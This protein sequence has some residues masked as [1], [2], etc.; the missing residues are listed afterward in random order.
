MILAELP[1]H[2]QRDCTLLC[3]S[4]MKLTISDYDSVHGGTFILVDRDGL[5]YRRGPSCFAVCY[6]GIFR[7]TYWKGKRSYF[8]SFIDNA[9]IIGLTNEE[10]LVS[11]GIRLS[12]SAI[13]IIEQN[14]VIADILRQTLA[15]GGLEYHSIPDI[16]AF[17][18][19]QRTSPNIALIL[20]NIMAT[21]RDEY[22]RDRPLWH[23]LASR[24]ALPIPVLCYTSSTSTPSDTP[25]FTAPPETITVASPSDFAE[26][27]QIAR[28]YVALFQRQSLLFAALQGNYLPSMRSTFREFGLDA[29]IR[30]LNSEEHTGIIILRE[31][32]RTGII[33]TEKGRVVHALVGAITGKDAFISM[34]R[35]KEAAI[36]YFDAM[37]IGENSIRIGIENLL[38]EAVSMDDEVQDLIAMIPKNSYVRRV[39]SYTDQLMKTRLTRTEFEILELLDRYH[40]VVDLV[41]RSHM[42]E[43]TVLKTLRMLMRNKLIE[44]VT[45]QTVREHASARPYEVG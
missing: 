12:D 21:G 4:Y 35:W 9:R 33:A 26:V 11:R 24:A 7:D 22:G 23:I 20:I 8:C 41:S 1:K 42:S 14:T 6:I 10:F 30:F 37:A 31:G 3:H 39:S 40:I 25:L 44:I 38:L 18:V 5:F 36:S 19:L 34:F 17:D 27:A 16:T 43:V 2:A 13:I 28:N 45:T 32:I 29:I 15:N